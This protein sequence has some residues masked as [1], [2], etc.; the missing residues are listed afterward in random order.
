LSAKIVNDEQTIVG[1]HLQRGFII[2][3]IM[4]KIQIERFKCEF[5][6]SD[7]NGSFNFNPS[8]VQRSIIF[9]VINRSMINLVIYNYYLIACQYSVWDIDF[10]GKRITD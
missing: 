10:I 6:A 5:P 8:S 3:R 7:Y 9:F 2:F 1:F 4:I